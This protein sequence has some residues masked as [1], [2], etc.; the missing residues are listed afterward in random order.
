MHLGSVPLHPDVAQ[1]GD[2]GAPIVITAQRIQ[3]IACRI[4]QRVAIQSF[5][6]LPVLQ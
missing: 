2:G 1:A 4:A 3:E 6:E 5:A